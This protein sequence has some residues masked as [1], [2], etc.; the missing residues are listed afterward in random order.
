MMVKL[1]LH[2]RGDDN[3]DTAQ[4]EKNYPVKQFLDS[5]GVQFREFN[6]KRTDGRSS[7][8]NTMFIIDQISKQNEKKKKRE[9]LNQKVARINKITCSHTY[10]FEALCN[11]LVKS[12]DI[13]VS[14]FLDGRGFDLLDQ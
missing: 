14:F 3:M 2:L 7:Q 12:G 5:L 1:K 9:L 11:E 8:S 10:D 6:S 13:S 4:T